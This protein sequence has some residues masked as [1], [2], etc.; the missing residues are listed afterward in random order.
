MTLR[1]R[2][3]SALWCREVKRFCDYTAKPSGRQQIELLQ[4]VYQYFD[5]RTSHLFRSGQLSSYFSFHLLKACDQMLYYL[6][7][8][9]I[10]PKRQSSIIFCR[11]DD[12]P[13]RF[14]IVCL[15]QRSDIIKLYR[16]SEG[17]RMIRRREFIK[18]TPDRARAFP[19]SGTYPDCRKCCCKG[20]SAVASETRRQ[21]SPGL[22]LMP[23]GG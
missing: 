18:I 12:L 11:R 4:I 17:G 7:F 15:R 19:A 10:H 2:S 23:W 8:F 13:N 3:P 16:I 9:I 5:S 6:P 20:R 22:R 14:E 21:R 1:L